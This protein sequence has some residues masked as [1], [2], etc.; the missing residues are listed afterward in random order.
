[1]E[2]AIEEYKNAWWRHADKH[3]K[4]RTERVYVSI[5]SIPKEAPED[6][7]AFCWYDDEITLPEFWL[8]TADSKDVIKDGKE[9]CQEA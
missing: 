1:M 7:E 4:A 3:D 5:V 9:C 2:A 6:G 8:E